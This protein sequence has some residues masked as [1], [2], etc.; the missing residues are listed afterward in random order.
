MPIPADTGLQ[1]FQTGHIYPRNRGTWANLAS[2]REIT[3]S[4]DAIGSS[5]SNIIVG[6]VSFGN[7]TINN[8]TITANSNIVILTTTTANISN[9]SVGMKVYDANIA[10]NTSVTSIRNS[11]SGLIWDTWHNW[12]NDPAPYFYWN[13]PLI[14]IGKDIVFNCLIN[15][16]STGAVTYEI[17]TTGNA[18][19]NGTENLR[20]VGSGNVDIPAYEG[21]FLAV[22]ANV[23]STGSIA[24]LEKMDINVKNEPFQLALNKVNTGSLAGTIS[25]RQVD[26]GRNSSYIQ[27]IQMTPHLFVGGTGY[28]QSGYVATDY[29]SETLVT[30]AFPQIVDKL[31]GGANIAIVDN[32]GNYID[33]NVDILVYALPEQYYADNSILE[34]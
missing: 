12:S 33:G 26:L 9:I 8:A 25:S 22:T 17:R 29:F 7:L 23:V 2:T 19:F 6:N 16:V 27:N 28:T 31:N 4:S 21:R 3:I 14:D 1:D 11:S 13:S 18:N 20:T 30:G 32:D 24:V 10:A 15:T 34:R 5:I